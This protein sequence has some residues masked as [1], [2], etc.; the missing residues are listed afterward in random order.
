MRS[1][2]IFAINP[3]S[4]NGSIIFVF[5]KK[6]K[7]ND[8]VKRIDENNINDDDRDDDDGDDDDREKDRKIKFNIQLLLTL[9]KESRYL[10]SQKR[11]SLCTHSMH[12]L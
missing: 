4:Q 9:I 5:D 6:S 2:F 7:N 10:F 8:D 3:I 12:S 1:V 11:I